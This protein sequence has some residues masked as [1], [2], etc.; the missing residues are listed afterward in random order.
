MHKNRFTDLDLNIDLVHELSEKYAWE[1]TKKEIK[2][3]VQTIQY[4]INTL[5]TTNGQSPFVSFLL[6]FMPDDEYVI[7]AALIQEEILE[8]R[9]EG[10]ENEVGIKM[11]TSF[12]KLIY[13]LD[14]HNVEKDSPFYHLTELSARASAKTLMPDY[15]S[16]KK[17]REHYEGN[18]FVPI[19]QPVA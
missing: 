19:D 10:I 3:G 9:L 5:S 4:Q 16:A 17:M 13:V 12:P 7:E 18:V 6:H 2:D 8:Q 15:I 14:E 1:D 11:P